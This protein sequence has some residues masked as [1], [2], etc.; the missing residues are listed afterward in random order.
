MAEPAMRT[1]RE[2]ADFPAILEAAGIRKSFGRKAVLRGVSFTLGRAEVLAL[3]G[4]NGCGK[5]TLLRCLNLLEPYEAGRVLLDERE[6]SS[7]V[8]PGHHFSGEEKER[9]RALRRRMVMIFQRFNLFPHLTVLQNVMCGPRYALGK[10]PDEARAVAE[11]ALRKVGLWEKHPCDPLTLSG[12]QQQRAAIAR[13]LA[14]EPEL[15]LLDEPTSSLDPV[16]T[17]EVFKVM[18]QLAADGMT[19]LLVTHDLDFARGAADRILFMEEGIITAQGAPDYI[20]G[21]QPTEGIRRFMQ[22]YP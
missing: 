1:A 20:F 18:R 21:A 5:S 9:A 6:V 15:L 11:R 13:A 12:G 14:M 7:G 22:E 2:A 19:M 8:P 3:L 4:P 16:M 10:P 17:K